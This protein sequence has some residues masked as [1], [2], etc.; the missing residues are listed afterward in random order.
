MLNKI[1]VSIFI[2]VF[3][4][5]VFPS[6]NSMCEEELLAKKLIING[7]YF[8]MDADAE[9][10]FKKIG[11]Q[12]DEM[13]TTNNPKIFVKNMI[14]LTAA[15]IALSYS[16]KPSDLSGLPITLNSNHIMLGFMK[17]DTIDGW[18]CLTT[19]RIIN[20]NKV[21]FYDFFTFT[22]DYDKVKLSLGLEWKTTFENPNVFT[23]FIHGYNNNRMTSPMS[24]AF[25][26]GLAKSDYYKLEGLLWF[27]KASLA[28]QKKPGTIENEATDVIKRLKLNIK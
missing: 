4:V 13:F 18:N 6:T 11:K 9:T 23:S 19:K 17:Y 24:K 14:L 12:I 7:T 8:L 5:I 25:G 28:F 26:D 27:L 16:I 15:E 21:F 22:S 1:F 3:S 20:G 2:T 10:N